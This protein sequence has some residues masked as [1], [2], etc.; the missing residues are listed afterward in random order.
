MTDETR[1]YDG[2]YQA[3]LC[4]WGTRLTATADK[5][6]PDLFQCG[7]TNYNMNTNDSLVT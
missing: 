2:S 5:G 3:I 7:A 1:I 4:K 6:A